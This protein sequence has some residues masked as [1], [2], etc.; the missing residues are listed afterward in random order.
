[1]QPHSDLRRGAKQWATL[2]MIAIFTLPCWA[3]RITVAQLEKTLQVDAARHKQPEDIVRQLGGIELTERLAEPDLRRLQSPFAGTSVAEALRLVADESAFLEPPANEIPTTAA[4]DVAAQQRMLA[5]A[6]TYMLKT[7]ARLPNFMATQATRQYD[8]S[9]WAMKKNEW[10]M[11]AGL[12]LVDSSTREI[13]IRDEG[14]SHLPSQASAMWRD[15]AG[16]I[17]GGEFGASLGMILTDI[18]K[19]K[20]SW[21]HWETKTQGTEAVFAYAVP[22]TASH[23]AVITALRRQ[24]QSE[25]TS[26]ADGGGR[27]VQGIGARPGAGVATETLD[28]SEAAYHGSL[29]I[30]PATGT[31]LRITIDADLK[32]AALQ[33]AAILVQY[34]PVTIGGSTFICPVR[35][36]AL[37]VAV[38]DARNLEGTAPT[39]WLNVTEYTDYHR[40]GSSVRVLPGKPQ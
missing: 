36:L 33:R 13:S 8:D 28:R 23:F 17:S 5:A 6:R 31:I 1:M 16:L 29:W 22:Q 12:H 19:G 7:L 39:E 14:E 38:P 9:P 15:Q 32:S 10:P 21:S 27:G 34:A 35:S 2:V 18:S 20:V 30:D 3:K 24:P 26:V 4:P 11:R 37:S 40:F 25:M